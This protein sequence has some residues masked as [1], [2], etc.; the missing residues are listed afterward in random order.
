MITANSQTDWWDIGPY[1]KSFFT[2]KYNS[3]I[4]FASKKSEG[5]W[6]LSPRL[7]ISHPVTE[8]SKLFFNYGHFKQMPSY[9]TLFQ[10]ARADDQTMKQFGDPNL[11]LAR[12]ISYEL[13]YDHSLFDD[14]L[15]QVSAFY[16]DITDQQ[17]STIYRS[18]G[19]IVYNQTTSNSYEDIRGFELSL[20]KRRG[21]WW[22]FFGN[23]TYQVSTAGHFG[24]E[25]V[26]QDG[27]QQKLYDDETTNLYQNRPIPTP[28]ARLN[29]S[30]YTPDDYG[31]ELLGLY[32]L[33]GYMLNLLLNWQDGPWRTYNPKNIAG[34]EN[35]VQETDYVISLLRLSKTFSLGK[36]QL[37]AFMDVNNL[38]NH[39]RMSLS[40]FTGK[41]GDEDYYYNSLHLPESEDWDNI[42]GDDRAGAYRKPGVAY[43]PMFPRGTI[44]FSSDKGDAGVIYYDKSRKNYYEYNYNPNLPNYQCW[45]VVSKARIDKIND[46]KA[47]IDMPAYSSFSFFNPRQFFFGLR[48]SMQLK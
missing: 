33:G 45:Q 15:I 38:L 35:N 46:D 1:D 20:Q 5:Q 22:T 41:Y 10:V 44:S 14:Y 7:G 40:N 37:M 47:Y 39:R 11:I 16:H 43:Q 28:Y 26:Y 23:Y 17:D 42:P 21:R 6:Q 30:L 8:N 2:T 18:I 19:G 34:L 3:S 4:D 27:V 25:E 13:G 36:F 32:P 31:P 48:V 24:R 9:Q 29:L 12:T